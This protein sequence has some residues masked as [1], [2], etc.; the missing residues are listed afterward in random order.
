MLQK[1]LLEHAADVPEEEKNDLW[2]DRAKTRLEIRPAR[3]IHRVGE[4]IADVER[5]KQSNLHVTKVM[6]G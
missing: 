6:N 2:L 5:E 3:L 4:Y 1:C